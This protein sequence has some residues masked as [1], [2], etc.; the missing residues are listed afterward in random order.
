MINN[1][2]TLSGAYDLIAKQ[3]KKI[4]E[5]ELKL[6]EKSEPSFD[7]EKIIKIVRDIITLSFVNNLY[8]RNK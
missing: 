8:G 2:Q 3:Q 6:K 7:P 4:L 5:L 1:R